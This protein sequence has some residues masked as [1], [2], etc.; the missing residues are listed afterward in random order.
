MEEEKTLILRTCQ[1]LH[2][3]RVHESYIP[4]LENRQQSCSRK[5]KGSAS[6]TTTAKKP[7]PAFQE[8]GWDTSTLHSNLSA[9][10]ACRLNAIVDFVGS[11]VGF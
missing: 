2:R 7:L 4:S 11:V 10:R 5:Q 1:I 3:K 9:K 8:R 6:H